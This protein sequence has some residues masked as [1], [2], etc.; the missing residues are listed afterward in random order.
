MRRVYLDHAA[1]TPLHEEVLEA[2]LPFLKEHFGNA[3]SIHG[4]G[5]EA[6]SAVE[7]AR[8][9]VAKAIGADTKEIFFTSGGTE[10]DNLAIQ[11][12]VRALRGKGKHIITSQIEH[13]AVLDTC[14]FLEKE[15]YDVTYVPVDE[16]GVVDP[17]QVA[18][19][20][21][22]DTLLISIM[23]ANNEVGSIQP[24]AEISQLAKKHGVYV[25]TDAV[26][27]VGSIPVDVNE[28]GVD[29]LT[30]SAHKFYGPKGIGAL[31]VRRGTPIK[32]IAHGGGQER[33][34]RPGTENVA[35]I[36]G[37]GKA[38]GIA[39]RDLKTE[40]QKITAMRDKLI[41]GI[42]ERIPHV[43]LNGHPEQRLPGNV[44]MSF[45]YVEGESLILALDMQGIGVS[46]G[47]ACTSGSL[48]PSH[49]LMSMGLDHQTAHGSLRM[50]LGRANSEEDI[51]YVL[52]V[53]P[54]VVDRLRQMSPL[55][56]R[57]GNKNEC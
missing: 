29:L 16:Y 5:R 11:G 30:L 51:D 41:N 50:T 8:E 15:G 28:L 35:G 55:Y 40:Q 7:K 42:F 25:H 37:L 24:I 26:Q 6:R 53:L 47:S 3:S 46:S 9:Q 2:M 20:I 27:A 44:N 13:H 56:H 31:Y 21:R 19:A 36:V 49:V 23:L 1:T 54:Q 14:Q 45:L 12:V 34:L 48:E 4:F 22:E 52:E 57:E 17:Q 33:K 38:I 32:P 18:K 10:S 43:R 39:V